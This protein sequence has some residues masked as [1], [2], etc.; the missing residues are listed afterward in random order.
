MKIKWH[1]ETVEVSRLKPY[2]KNPRA[3]TAKGMSDLRKSI[4]KFGLAEPI[5][6]NTDFTVIGGHA[7][8]KALT[9][10][11]ATECDVYLP[12]RKLTAKECEELNIRLNANIAGE[13]D[14]DILAN[15]FEVEELKDWGLLLNEYDVTENDNVHIGSEEN[16]CVC[17]TCGVRH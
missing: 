11:G 3:F 14:Y 5:V 17:P 6:C 2:A 13:W 7:R 1:I 15:E 8:L 16:G 9:T 4:D 12:S 10:D